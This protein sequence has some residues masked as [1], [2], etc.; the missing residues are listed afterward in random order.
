MNVRIDGRFDLKV[1]KIIFLYVVSIWNVWGLFSFPFLFTFGNTIE[2]VVLHGVLVITKNKFEEGINCR[3][4]TIRF[5]SHF[6]TESKRFL[7]YLL[8]NPSIQYIFPHI[9][10][11]NII[12]FLNINKIM[13]FSLVLISIYFKKRVVKNVFPC[14][15]VILKIVFFK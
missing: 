15:S 13:A 10:Y 5:Y 8:W 7:V 11:F 3:T 4:F 14:S 12:R 6:S 9:T 2:N 1:N